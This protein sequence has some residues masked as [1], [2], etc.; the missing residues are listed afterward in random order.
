[1][2][3][4]GGPVASA[5]EASPWDR[6]HLQVLVGLRGHSLSRTWRDEMAFM[7]VDA[8]RCRQPRRWAPA[9]RT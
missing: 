1:M 2:V 6:L 7:L 8:G 9:L 3:K 5:W 4:P